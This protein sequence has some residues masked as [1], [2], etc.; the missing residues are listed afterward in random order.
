MQ[1]WVDWVP[2]VLYC[3]SLPTHNLRSDLPNLFSRERK[4]A[5]KELRRE[6]RVEKKVNKLAFREEQARQIKEA[7]ANRGNAKGVTKIT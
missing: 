1:G 6:R 5:V 4:A 7:S 3:I 2:I